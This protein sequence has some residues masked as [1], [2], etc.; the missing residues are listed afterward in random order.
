MS[1]DL[2]FRGA[3][4]GKQKSKVCQNQFER[5]VFFYA[6]GTTLSDGGNCLLPRKVIENL[7]LG[8]F[9]GNKLTLLVQ[10]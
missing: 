3:K 5:K 7:K 2:S 4:R 6:G 9:E 8:N 10:K 1:A